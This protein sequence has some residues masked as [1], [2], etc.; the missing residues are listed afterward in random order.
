MA[1]IP[2][3]VGLSVGPTIHLS[4]RP[5]IGPSIHLSARPSIGPSI[6]LSACLSIG[7]SIHLSVRPSIGPTIHLSARLSIGPSIHLSARPSIGPSMMIKL[8]S[9]KTRNYDAAVMIVS[10]R[11]HGMGE[12]MD[13]GVCPYP[14]VH[15]NIATPHHLLISPRLEGRSTAYQ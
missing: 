11:E 3:S 12:G 4:A 6:H 10:V 8:K 14:P 1:Q 9:V 15:N 13:G 2:W 5:S 7:P